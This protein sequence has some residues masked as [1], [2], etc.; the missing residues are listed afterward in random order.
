M[1]RLVEQWTQAARSPLGWL[2]ILTVAVIGL[3]V[4]AVFTAI[5]LALALDLYS[6]RLTQGT[7]ISLSEAFRGYLL[8]WL[9]W[10]LACPV[11]YVFARR[12]RIDQRLDRR[13]LL[14]HLAFLGGFFLL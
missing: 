5:Q 11:L 1:N 10:I 2:E 4:M 8:P 12:Y 6:R 13:K 14:V 9:L 3:C 7:P